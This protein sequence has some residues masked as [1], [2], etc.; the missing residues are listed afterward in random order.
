MVS[1]RYQLAFVGQ[2]GIPSGYGVL[3]PLWGKAQP[4]INLSRFKLGEYDSAFGLFLRS[5][6]PAA[7]IA[8]ARRMTEL[9]QAYM[10]MLPAIFRV[11]TNYV[12]PW[13]LGFS[14]PIFKPYWKFLDIDIALQRKMQG[15]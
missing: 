2:G 9:A 6:E 11:E 14:P 1:G 4:S 12:Q 13:V 15:R 10:P 8:A 5:S 7:Q 3:I